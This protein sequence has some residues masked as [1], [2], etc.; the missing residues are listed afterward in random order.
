MTKYQRDL[1]AW[2]RDQE[3]PT[4]ISSDL[5][6]ISDILPFE[7]HQDETKIRKMMKKGV[8]TLPPIWITDEFDLIDGHHRLMAYI[9]TRHNKIPALLFPAET[10]DAAQ[11]EL[12][13]AR[14][15]VAE[16]LLA[17]NRKSR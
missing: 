5:V 14:L 9:L 4:E 12:D 1:L 17:V 2:I 6:L 10:I 3:L 7:F 11:I 8:S 15:D 16:L 13:E